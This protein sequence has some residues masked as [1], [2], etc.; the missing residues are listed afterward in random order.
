[1]H[2]CF[3]TIIYIFILLRFTKFPAL[4]ILIGKNR[5]EQQDSFSWA[6]ITLCHCAC[7]NHFS[8]HKLYGNEKGF[9]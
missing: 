8:M 5:C 6:G 3:I 9:L 1:M 7:Q 4:F 2:G